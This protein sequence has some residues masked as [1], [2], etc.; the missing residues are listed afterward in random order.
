MPTL[1]AKQDGKY[2]VNGFT[3]IDVDVTGGG[4]SSPSPATATPQM[5]GT[6][7]VGTSTKYAR[8]DHVHPSDT[9]KV[10]KVSGKGL[11]TNDFTNTLKNKL[12]GIASGAEVNVQSD[13]NQSTNTADDYIKNKPTIPTKTSDLTNDSGFLTSSQA[14]KVTFTVVSG[15]VDNV[16]ISNTSYSTQTINIAVPAGSSRAAMFYRGCSIANASSSGANAANCGMCWYFYDEEN[17]AYKVN[18]RNFKGSSAKVKVTLYL[19]AAITA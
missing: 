4:G 8:E 13:W 7:A 18:I 5:D 10:D 12:D 6:G 3:T 19:T 16:S 9:S 14:N 15:T 17:D 2:K 1:T 11:S